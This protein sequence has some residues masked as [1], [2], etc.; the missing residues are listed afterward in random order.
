MVWAVSDPSRG[1]P[2]QDEIP[3]VASA[4]PALTALITVV[5]LSLGMFGVGLKILMEMGIQRSNSYYSPYHK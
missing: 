2:P 4:W 3:G 5:V 1:E